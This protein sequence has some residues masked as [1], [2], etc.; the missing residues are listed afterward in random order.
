MI[1][2]STFSD[3]FFIISVLLVNELIMNDWME[4]NLLKIKVIH[5]FCLIVYMTHT[6]L[7][8]GVVTLLNYIISCYFSFIN[9]RNHDALYLEYTDELFNLSVL[10]INKPKIV[11][12]S[13]I[14][15]IRFSQNM[16]ELFIY[17]DSLLWN[18]II[19]NIM[20][21]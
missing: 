14:S 19:E 13:S 20:I 11:F 9:I 16:Y 21:Y 10:R 2:D 3:L 15:D 4:R 6:L 12:S 18:I 5:C 1:Y 17:G 7:W 8:A